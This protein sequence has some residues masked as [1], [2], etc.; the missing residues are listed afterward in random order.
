MASPS[1]VATIL[2]PLGFSSPAGRALMVLRPENEAAKWA[3]SQVVDFIKEQDAQSDDED[4]V[5]DVR[6]HYAK[7][8]WFSDEQVY[9]SAVSRFVNHSTIVESPSSPSSLSS[10]TCS[11][12]EPCPTMIWTGFYFLDSNIKTLHSDCG[13]LI[14]RLSKRGV[15]FAQPTVDI[16]L[17]DSRA[18]NVA[19]RHAVINFSP[20]TR[21]AT[22]SLE[23]GNSAV[24]NATSLTSK[25][26]VAGCALGQNRIHFGDLMYSLE[27]TSYC[28]RPQGQT[29]LS[30]HI[31][32]IHG[33]NQPTKEILQATPTPQ[34][35]NVQTIGKYT[36]TGGLT[37]RG[38][39]GRVRPAVGPDGQKIVAVKTMEA[40]P[41]RIQ[42]TREK[43]ALMEF[44]A[45]QAQAEKQQNVLKM[46]ESIHIKGRQVD[47]FHIILEPYVG[48]TLS[49]IPKDVHYTK[50]E[51]ILHDC[52][53]GLAFLH[54]RGIVHTDIKPEN[55]GLLDFHKNEM[56]K[57]AHLASYSRPPRTAILDI[58]SMEQIPN[59]QT[60]IKAAP[61]SNGTVGFHSPEH[62][63]TEYDGRTDVWALGVSLFRAIFGV[64]P[65][66][67]GT[68]GNPWRKDRDVVEAREKF[69]ARYEK[70]VGKVADYYPNLGEPL[71][72]FLI[73]AFRFPDS[74]MASQRR[75][76]PTSAEVSILINGQ[77]RM[78]MSNRG[79]GR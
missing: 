25:G 1:S 30:S 41:T 71:C 55:I 37:G 61:G 19:R 7:F 21:L 2:D 26:S 44:I 65:W 18:G 59:G 31:T 75:I 20:E 10:S 51:L 11:L 6:S 48:F 28:L 66:S 49:E 17:T 34:T 57:P 50:Y 53:R 12:E 64:F 76:R 45:Q 8:M 32:G 52:L 60:A 73:A 38:T 46:I 63:M 3:F 77:H 42:Y 68:E 72:D 54:A 43:I 58:D 23:F 39:F 14:G 15:S 47:E 62:E 29:D 22:V 74:E 79:R 27:Y 16:L 56:N 33:D 36:I 9:D 78:L 70:A 67:Y 35:T 13:W 40:R 24:V 4:L 69:H 5:T